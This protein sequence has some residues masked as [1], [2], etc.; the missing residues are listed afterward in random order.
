MVV[1]QTVIRFSKGT[2]SEHDYR[3]KP[4]NQDVLVQNLAQHV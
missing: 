4:L 3:E 1:Q 2:S